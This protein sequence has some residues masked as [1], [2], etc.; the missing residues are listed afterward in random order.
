MGLQFEKEFDIKFKVLRIIEN[1]NHHCKISIKILEQNIFGGQIPDTTAYG[2]FYRIYEEDVF[3]SKALLKES[4]KGDFYVE[5]IGI[6][7]LELP[8]SV[9]ALAKYAEKQIPGVSRKTIIKVS[10]ILGNDFITIL[11]ANHKEIDKVPKLSEN[12]KTAIIEWCASKS[13]LEALVGE[14]NIYGVQPSHAIKIFEQFGMGSIGHLTRDPYTLYLFDCISFADVDN[15]VIR[16]N[17]ERF[18]I[19]DKDRM[20]AM[21]LCILNQKESE[22]SMGVSRRTLSNEFSL[23]LNRYKGELVPTY[24]ATE[25]DIDAAIN[26]LQSKNII[27]FYKGVRDTYFLKP[28]NLYAERTIAS[29][30][31]RNAE[32]SSNISKMEIRDIIDQYYS[33]FDK[34]Q[35][36]TEQEDAVMRCCTHKVSILTG[37]PGTGKTFTVNAIIKVLQ[38]IKHVNFKIKLLAPTGKAASRMTQMVSESGLVAET[39]HS[40]LGLSSESDLK[41]DERKYITEDWV[42]ID[43]A[44]MIEEKL[45][46]YFLEHIAPETKIILCGDSNQ[47]PSVGPGNLFLQLI[48]SKKVAYTQLT[49]VFRTSKT[50]QIAV[51]ANI[52]KFADREKLNKLEFD[53]D[54]TF[55]EEQN[56]GE[57]NRLIVDYYRRMIQKRGYDQNSILVLTPMHKKMA[58]TIMLNQEIQTLLNPDAEDILIDQSVKLKVGDRIVQKV[59]DRKKGIHNGDL[60]TILDI[61]RSVNGPLFTIQFDGKD[62]KTILEGADTIELAYALTVHKAQGSEAEYVLMPFIESHK[63]MLKN[64]LIYTAITRAKK[65]FIGIGS[66][67]VFKEGC[68]KKEENLRP[69]ISL[70]SEMMEVQN[71]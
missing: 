45:F 21:L 69:R 62:T 47:L 3:T 30:I 53:G 13:S 33:P 64:R 43:E 9:D 7:N 49:Q 68:C 54:F 14:L 70:I 35:L 27:S 20:S 66:V 29:Y 31:K 38:N 10:E 32:I 50:G 15:L 58:G 34:Q 16:K 56:E 17:K 12:K 8:G 61:Q 37:G 63:T 24:E 67:E 60:G 23:Y 57:V 1:T 36:S 65:R 19:N 2:L 11:N 22:G 25:K 18:V 40:A 71:A 59:N 26:G 42:I 55:I 41:T 51:N 46:S 44:S 48:I 39:M 4:R 5:L 28:L 52:I 6:P